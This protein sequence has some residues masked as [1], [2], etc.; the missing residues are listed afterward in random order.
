M[1]KCL[2]IV[3]VC[4]MATPAMAGDVSEGALSALGLGGMEVMS[5]AEGMQVRG[6]SSNSQGTS[7]T[8]FTLNLFDPATGADLSVSDSAFGRV[9]DENAGLNAF[10]ATETAD[11]V[12]FSGVVI[13]INVQGI[14][15]YDAVVLP[16]QA[17]QIHVGGSPA[18]VNLITFSVVQF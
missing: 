15:T 4:L 1:K 2:A 12:Q 10:S 9:T 13:D 3:A 6:M 8:Q 16:F 18:P 5:D 17:A 11:A 14:D 7:L